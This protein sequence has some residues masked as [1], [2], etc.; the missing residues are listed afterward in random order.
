V[1]IGAAKENVNVKTGSGRV[2][3]SEFDGTAFAAKTVSGDISVRVPTG[4][5]LRVDLKTLSGTVRLPGDPAATAD[6]HE[7][8]RQITVTGKTVSGDIVVATSS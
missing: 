8:E 4:R 3:I 6:R 2:R 5:T 1:L 7:P